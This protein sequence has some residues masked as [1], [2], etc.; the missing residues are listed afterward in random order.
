MTAV[1]KL[2]AKFISVAMGKPE[3]PY[4]TDINS[5]LQQCLA[6][7]SVH[8]WSAEE[9]DLIKVNER[10][11]DQKQSNRFYSIPSQYNFLSFSDSH[12][13]IV[14]LRDIKF[15]AAWNKW[16]DLYSIYKEDTLPAFKEIK[17]FYTN[18]FKLIDGF[19]FLIKIPDKSAH[20]L[21]S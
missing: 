10:S 9:R 21:V 5:Y 2:N 18:S 16:G 12:I 15:V 3:L 11:A 6:S 4:C 8:Q 17:E 1:G 14:F 20:T 19:K 13:Q 7:T